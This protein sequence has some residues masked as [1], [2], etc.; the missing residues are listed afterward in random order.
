[1]QTSG[2]LLWF[3]LDR[4]IKSRKIKNH[5]LFGAKDKI[6]KFGKNLST[7]T[8]LPNI[9]IIENVNLRVSS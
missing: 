5:S 3:F 1:M 8:K 9:K 2:K 7:I 6:Q 4:K